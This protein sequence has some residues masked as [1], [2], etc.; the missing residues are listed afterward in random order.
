MQQALFETVPAP[1]PP[2]PPIQ[3]WWRLQGQARRAGRRVE[4]LLVTPRFMARIDAG[5]CPVTRELLRP[6]SAV[7][8]ALRADAAVAA[9]HLATLGAVA[10][11]AASDAAGGGRWVDAWAVA[12]R[13]TA[14]PAPGTHADMDAAAWRRLAVLRS[15][16]QPLTP[17][18]AGMLP[19][20][21]LPTNRLRVLSPVQGLQVAATLALR[22]ADRSVRLVQLAA[23]AGTEDTRLAMR[24]FVLTLVARCPAGLDSMAPAEARQALED[25]WTDPLLQRRWQ[26]LALRLSDAEAESLLLRARAAR[27]FG[28]GWRPLDAGFAVDGWELPAA[29]GSESRHA[30]RPTPAPFPHHLVGPVLA[31]GRR[32]HGADAGV[33]AAVGR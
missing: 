25:L 11:A 7:V 19:L 10:A 14:E 3:R 4:P 29:T 13:L 28:K 1:M 6:R 21:A 27:L 2:L 30:P 5:T 32:R 8:V 12:Q 31:A 23:L 24:V 17:A 26:R 33:E 15:F 9:G 22:G 18:E 20:L 16:V